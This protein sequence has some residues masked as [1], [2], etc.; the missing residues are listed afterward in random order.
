VTFELVLHQLRKHN[1][2]VLSTVG[3]D[4]MADSAGVNYGLARKDAEFAIY[5]MTRRHLKKAR[6]IARNPN[7]S[8]VI[9]L[10][11]RLL[12]FLPPPCIQFSGRAEILDWTNAA[13]IAAF[14]RFWMGR[15]ILAMYEDAY[16]RGETRPC[17]VKITPEPVISTYM[18]GYS[19]WEL[20]S[21][22][23]LAGAKV[24]IPQ[25][26]LPEQAIGADRVLGRI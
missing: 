22:G 9:P 14:T 24:R 16:Q 18:V 6:N 21:R 1:F 4:G 8:L 12:W 2:A 5:V 20:R 13:G 15:R 11:R 23:E 25:E 3:E 26:L 19:A 17:F 10:A 7:V